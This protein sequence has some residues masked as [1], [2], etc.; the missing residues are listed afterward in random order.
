M[1]KNFSL[2]IHTYQ[3]SDFPRIFL[4]GSSRT[5]SSPLASSSQSFCFQ[6]P[7]EKK[8]LHFDWEERARNTNRVLLTCSQRANCLGVLAVKSQSSYF[9]YQNKTNMKNLL[10]NLFSFISWLLEEIIVTF[11]TWNSIPNHGCVLLFISVCFH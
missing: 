10:F 4:D 11:F 2:V 9:H 8:I 7:E 5:S 6:F 1:T 3:D